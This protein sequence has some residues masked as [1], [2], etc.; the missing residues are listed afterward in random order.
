MADMTREETRTK[1]FTILRSVCGQRNPGRLIRLR[2]ITFAQYVLEKIPTNKVLP[3]KRRGFP[4]AL[5]A[6]MMIDTLEDLQTVCKNKKGEVC[7]Q[8]CE[9]D[10]S[11]RLGHKHMHV[12]LKWNFTYTN[13]S[14]SMLS[15]IEQTA[16]TICTRFAKYERLKAM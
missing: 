7:S 11:A 10:A 2:N 3:R 14:V 15:H 5:V 9:I 1:W 6:L 8:V 4:P 16:S 13:I 12:V